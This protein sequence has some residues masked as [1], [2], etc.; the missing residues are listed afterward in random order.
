MTRI[1]PHAVPSTKTL[2]EY[3][4][5]YTKAFLEDCATLPAGAPRAW[6]PPPSNDDMVGRSNR[7]GAGNHLS[8]RTVGVLPDFHLSGIRQALAQRFLSGNLAGARVDVDEY[9]RPTPAISRCGKRPRKASRSGPPPSAPCRPDGTSSAPRWP[10]STW[11]RRW[12]FTP[13]RRSDLPR[14]RK[15]DAQSDRSPA[16]PAAAFGCTPSSSWWRARDVKSLGNYY[17]LRDLLDRGYQPEAI[18]Y[19]AGFGAVRKSLNFTSTAEI[20][21]HRHRPPA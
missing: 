14:T 15:R 8:P 17:T 6:S 7:L 21:R 16:N 1:I 18:R 4:E 2:G 9:E 11:A 19:H 3:T 12:I 10:S 20:V 13:R 5:I